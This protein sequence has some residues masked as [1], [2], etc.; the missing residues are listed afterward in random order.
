M[1]NELQY[2][3]FAYLGLGIFVL[4][5]VAIIFV[6]LELIKNRG[7]CLRKNWIELLVGVIISIGLILFAASPVVTWNDKLLFVLTDSSTLTHY[8]SIF[9]ATGRIIWPVNYLIYVAVIVC[10]A[11]LW[12]SIFEKGDCNIKKQQLLGL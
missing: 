2:E 7:R 11:K 12:D 6:A 3:G 9:R 4:M 8:W 1:Y 5:L 10:N